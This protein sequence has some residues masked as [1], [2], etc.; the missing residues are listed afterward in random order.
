MRDLA[1]YIEYEML[2]T[3]IDDIDEM[4]CTDQTV[5]S[6]LFDSSESC[7]N[8]KEWIGSDKVEVG[9]R[10]VSAGE[11]EPCAR[12]QISEIPPSEMAFSLSGDELTASVQEYPTS[13]DDIGDHYLDQAVD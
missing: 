11:D 4:D 9:V 5:Y 8:A 12:V 13:N 10:S 1:R 3:C 6:M 2:T 7:N